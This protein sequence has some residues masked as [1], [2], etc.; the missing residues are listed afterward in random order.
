MGILALLSASPLPAQPEWMD[1]KITGIN[2]L[3][4]RSSAVVPFYNGNEKDCVM[5]G[6]EWKFQLVKKP[7]DRI[8]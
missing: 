7:A 1:P 6:G 4:P 3:P 5:L 8:A 2:T